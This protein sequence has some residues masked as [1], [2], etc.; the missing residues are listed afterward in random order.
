[1][2][3]TSGRPRHSR[4]PSRTVIAARLADDDLVGVQQPSRAPP[5]RFASNDASG[6]FIGLQP[7]RNPS[8]TYCRHERPRPQQAP[9]VARRRRR[10]PTASPSAPTR[11]PTSTDRLST[12]LRARRHC[13]RLWHGPTRSG[14]HDAANGGPDPM[15]QRGGLHNDQSRGLRPRSRPL[16]RNGL[17]T[18]IV[19]RVASA[20]DPSDGSRRP[21]AMRGLP[22]RAVR[23]PA[24]PHG[25]IP[26]GGLASTR[27]ARATP[28]GTRCRVPAPE[29]QPRA[30]G[31]VDEPSRP[32]IA[33]QPSDVV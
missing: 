5:R 23:Q 26:G 19:R 29:A 12:A 32:S 33:S 1:M 3:A 7:R 18:Q 27:T 4:S 21:R 9:R 24:R 11:P 15:A 8:E 28:A 2:N 14:L 13:R 31:S 17:A 16:P 6:L 22:H 20:Q 30:R 25:R 10:H